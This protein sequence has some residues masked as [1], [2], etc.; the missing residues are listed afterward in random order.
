MCI[1]WPR[2]RG[3]GGPAPSGTGKWCGS[4]SDRFLMAIRLH[5]KF[6]SSLVHFVE[7][8]FWDGFKCIGNDCVKNFIFKKCT[9]F[10]QKEQNVPKISGTFCPFC[11]KNL[12]RT[13][14]P[15]GIFCPKDRSVSGTFQPG[16]LRPGTFR[17][18]TFRQ[19]TLHSSSGLQRIRIY[20]SFIFEYRIFW[21]ISCNCNKWCSQVKFELSGFI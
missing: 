21:K 8:K 14:R 19:G 18:G 13:V 3:P 2:R 11:S 16:T 1:L 17:P 12:G 4:G 7:K 10:C 15:E 9:V 20:I 5:K 6:G